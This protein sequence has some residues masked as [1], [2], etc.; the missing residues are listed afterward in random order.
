M[1]WSIEQALQCKYKMRVIVS[2]DDMN[3]ADVARK[4]GAEV[5]FLRPKEISQDLSTD[6]EFIQHALC[7]L[8]KYDDYVPDVVVQ[9]R[10]TYPTRTVALLNDCLDTFL[11][12]MKTYDSLRTV[13][14][15]EKSPYKMY[16]IV[17][18][19]LRP[20]CSTLDN[21][22][23][24]YNLCRQDLPQCYLH[25]GCIDILRANI[26][27]YETITGQMIYPYVMPAEETHDIDTAADLEAAKEPSA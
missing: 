17:N 15:I 2:T 13:I 21:R 9:L 12:N 24:P 18:G 14:P 11:A 26:V 25:N 16:R 8:E 20:V 22:R 7:W 1:A 10:P 3:Y 23:E 5:P 27:R 19:M 4:Y 6:F